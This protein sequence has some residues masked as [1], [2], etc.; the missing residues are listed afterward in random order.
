MSADVLEVQNR[1][2]PRRAR[3]R[4]IN[5]IILTIALLAALLTLAR[6]A[7]VVTGRTLFALGGADGR[8][9]LVEL[10]QLLQAE[11]A[12]GATGYLADLE[13]GMRLLGASPMFVQ[14]VVFMVAALALV[15][16]VAGVAKARPFSGVV[17]S[18]WK[19][20]TAALLGGGLLQGALDTVAFA[21]FGS[22]IGL[23]FGSGMDVSHEDK[24]SFLG[25]TYQGIGM[26]V[27]QWPFL[28][29]IAGLAALA[30]AAAFRLGAK[31]E[32]EA[33]G[34]A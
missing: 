18:N 30:L 6:V 21:Y 9:S 29:I 11:L 31:L 2:R 14:A 15:R 17:Q 26:G 25:A 3:Y 34:V 32:R 10:P 1:N 13:L 5:A 24:A 33:D 19:L 7:V 20:L 27:P 16:I 28:I 22:R 12:D 23:F 8:V 4:A